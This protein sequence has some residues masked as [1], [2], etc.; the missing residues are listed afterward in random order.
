MPEGAFAFGAEELCDFYQLR[1][2]DPKTSWNDDSSVIYRLSLPQDENSVDSS[3]A[4]LN[5]LLRQEHEHSAGRTSGIETA[6]LY[7]PLNSQFRLEDILDRNKVPHNE[8]YKYYIN[9]KKFSS[10]L[11]LRNLHAGDAFEDLASSL[12]LLDR[13][14]QSQ[15]ED[16]KRLVQHNFVK[17]VRSKNN[18]DRIYDQFNKF[19][20]EGHND[21]GTK[22]LGAAVDDT[23]RDITLKVKPILDTNTKVKN[24]QTTIAFIQEHREFF[25]IPRKLKQ[26]LLDQDFISLLS[27][28][29]KAQRLYQDLKNK[30]YSFSILQKLWS[31]IENIIQNYQEVLWDSLNGLKAG[32]TQEHLLPLISKLASRPRCGRES[33]TKVD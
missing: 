9:S 29:H 24:V 26:C 4:V 20:L 30:G 10:K 21:L 1:S 19:S 23:I 3:Y 13:S 27:E 25:D 8:R 18:L 17:Y 7:D 32:E 33:N 14:L 22:E 12:D 31:E 11:Y 6:G 15:S 16:L 5:E 2:L 28:Y